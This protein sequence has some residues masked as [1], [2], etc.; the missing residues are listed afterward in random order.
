MW[1]FECLLSNASDE[2]LAHNLGQLVTE[3]REWIDRL[4]ES[5][6]HDEADVDD[7]LKVVA[8]E[9]VERA[10]TAAARMQNGIDL[11]VT[12]SDAGRAFRLANAAM[13]MQRARQDW[14]RGGAV[15]AVG[16]GAE[17]SWRPFQI[18][19]VLLNLPGLADADHEDRDIADLLWFPTGGGKT[20]AYLGL[21]AFTIFHR[22]LK[23]PGTLGVAVIMRYTLRLL[24][25]QQFERATMLLCSLERIRQRENDLGTARSRS[26]CGLARA[27]RRIRWSKCVSH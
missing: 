9:H 20:E 26:A 1:T 25:I 3:Y 16:D 21:V 17:Q 13:Q 4:S 27:Q 6:Q 22:R 23:D 5:V 14:V 11:I 12:D 10:R 18:A 19:Y 24:T 8:G 2:E 7:G 15:G